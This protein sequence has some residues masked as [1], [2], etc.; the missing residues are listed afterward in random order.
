MVLLMDSEETIKFQPH[1]CIAYFMNC[2]EIYF[3]FRYFIMS[4]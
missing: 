4:R 3:F 1:T 2:S